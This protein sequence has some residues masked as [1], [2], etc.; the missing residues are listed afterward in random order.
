[1]TEIPSF[2]SPLLVPFDGSANAEVVLPFV[3][4][5]VGAQRQAIL[6]QVVPEAREIQSA[7]G[8]VKLTAEELQAASE[9]AARAAL[10][11]A[12]DQLAERDQNL[13][14]EEMVVAGDP[15][16]QIARVAKERHV[17]GILLSSQGVSAV[18]PGG[19]G[20][21][22]GRVVR[23][24]PAPVMVIRANPSCP[25]AEIARLVIAHDG[26]ARANRALPVAQELAKRLDA[27]VHVVAVVNDERSPIADSAAVS[28]DPHVLE[29]FQGDARR[30]A[31]HHLEGVGASL[32]RMGQPATWQVLTGPAAPAII[33]ALAPNDVL[34]LT[35]YGRTGS[36]W[37]IGSIAEKLVRECPVPVLLVRSPDDRPGPTQ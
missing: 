8:D 2:G 33:D 6:L 18:G 25:T 9:T 32:L 23:T 34:V 3:P 28:L 15:S 16:D 27:H 29:M 17:G 11:R 14:I 37:M 36:R 5:L 13:L 4:L 7:L 10:E 24:A 30:A 22:V 12:A 31:Q 20:S 19:F 26:S 35:P 1:M 21:V